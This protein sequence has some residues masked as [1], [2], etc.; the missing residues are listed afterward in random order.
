MAVTSYGSDDAWQRNAVIE[1]SDGTTAV[2]I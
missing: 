2:D 1:I